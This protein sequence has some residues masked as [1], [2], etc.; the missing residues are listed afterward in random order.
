MKPSCLVTPLSQ[1][2][3]KNR[4]AYPPRVVGFVLRTEAGEI[5]TSGTDGANTD[6]ISIGILD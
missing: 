2:H 5:D 3:S 6:P 4:K 1:I